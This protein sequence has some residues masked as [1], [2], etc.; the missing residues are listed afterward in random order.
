MKRECSKVGVGIKE[1]KGG[2]SNLVFSF[3]PFRRRSHQ[4]K[5]NLDLLLFFHHHQPST[6][7]NHLQV[8]RPKLTFLKNEAGLSDPRKL[9]TVLAAQPRALLSAS[10]DRHLKPTVEFFTA[11][12]G[13]GGL[14]MRKTT[15]ARVA[16]ARPILLTYDREEQ[17][18]PK[19]KFFTDLGLTVPQV[20]MMV[21]AS[22]DVLSIGIGND[23]QPTVVGFG[24][25]GGE[26]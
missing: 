13:A 19:V 1:L 8:L 11:D 25:V 20:R 15:L 10:L 4:K 9:G 2:E 23:L 7:K 22:P 6:K 21:A 24:D 12:E 26:S 18:A 17:L 5:K 14:G 3:F 16:A